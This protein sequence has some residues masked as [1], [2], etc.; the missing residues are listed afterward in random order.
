MRAPR[1]LAD[2]TD[3]VDKRVLVTVPIVPPFEATVVRMSDS[4]HIALW[5]RGDSGS[6]QMIYARNCKVIGDR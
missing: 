5:L 3:W 6:E 4:K 1:K 2:G